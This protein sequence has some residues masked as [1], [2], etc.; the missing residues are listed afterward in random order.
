M[1]KYRSRF[2]PSP[3]HGIVL[4]KRDIALIIVLFICR[5]M[6]TSMIQQTFFTRGGISRCRKRLRLL[7]DWGFVE[8]HFLP[9]S[10]FGSE[11][12]HT[13]GKAGMLYALKWYADI[14]VE[15]ETDDARTQMN[16]PSLSLLNHALNVAR[17]YLACRKHLQG[18]SGIRMDRWLFERLVYAQ[19][20]VRVASADTG[21]P[22]AWKTVLFKPDAAL[23]VS[24]PAGSI[25]TIFIEA[26]CG[27][28]TSRQIATKL[29]SQQL[30]LSSGQFGTLYGEERFATIL[31]TTG[32]MSGRVLNLAT[33]AKRVGAH[34]VLLTT[35]DDFIKTGPLACDYLRPSGGRVMLADALLGDA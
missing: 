9:T 27:T 7:Y 2:R 3:V 23:Q 34:F 32:S 20:D 26:D 21:R 18:E 10:P 35:I 24:A 11:A 25:R 15:V 1:T 13:V 29:E 6:T 14:G 22:S 30:F 31:A 4:Q 12:V 5:C 16:L 17:L 19:F 33:I 8:R 28:S